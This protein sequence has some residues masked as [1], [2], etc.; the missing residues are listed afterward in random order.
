MADKK[1]R[2]IYL[3]MIVIA[4]TQVRETHLKERR[5]YVAMVVVPLFSCPSTHF[6][7]FS[8]KTEESPRNGH[9]EFVLDVS[10]ISKFRV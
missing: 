2:T 6:I 9:F 4:Q 1:S 5:R 3:V 7:I 10:E 8:M